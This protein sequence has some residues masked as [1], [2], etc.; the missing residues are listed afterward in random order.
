[1]PHF[2]DSMTRTQKAMVL[3]GLDGLAMAAAL[4]VAL[5]LRLGDP[6][7][8]QYFADGY[9]LWVL[10]P[11][12]G[13]LLSWI[14]G[15]PRIVLR[16]F[17]QRALFRLVQFAFIMSLI[18]A[19]LNTGLQFGLP[20]SIP[21][22]WAAVFLSFAI[23]SRLV[24]LG[25]IER[26]QQGGAGRKNVLVYGAGS[27]GQQLA[28]AL[29]SRGQVNPVGFLDDNPT[30][31]KVEVG[32]LRVHL[33]Q[34]LPSLIQRYGV[35]Q[36]ILAMPSVRPVDRR[37]KL[38]ALAAAGVEVLTLPSFDQ[39]LD[40]RVLTEQVRPV[41]T[42]ELLGRAAVDL[43]S[44]TVT[45]A[46]AGKVVMISGAGGS[47]GSELARQVVLAGPRRI[48]LFEQ[49]EYA[50]Y[51]IEREMQ[52]KGPEVVA[53]LGSVTDRARVDEV[54]RHQQV[55][56]ILHAA[57][58][59]HVPMIERNPLEGV[60]NNILGTASIADAA[61]AFGVERFILISTDKAVRPTNV[62]GATKRMA[63]LVVQDRQTRGGGTIFSMVR[64]G[65]VLGSSGSVIPLFREQIRNGGPVT[66][67]DP[68]VTRFFMTIPEAAQLVL[69]AGSYAEGGE[70]FV[71]D[72]GKPVK[73]MDL[74][75]S[76]IELSGFTVR[77]ENNRNGDIEIVTTGLR[78]GEKLY[79]ELLIDAATIATPHP[80]ILRA[81]EGHLSAED[82]ARALA[83]FAETVAQDRGADVAGL[84]Q[85]WLDGYTPTTRLEKRAS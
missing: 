10:V 23:F 6:W 52:D 34:A 55:D 85:K 60:R 22:I 20:R 78:P 59:K 31:R 26:L 41:S 39:L 70:V 32:G 9:G 35:D 28:A 18:T 64:F 65:N 38:E 15:V 17:E 67:T 54:L 82:T 83:Q 76:L 73:I 61:A 48:V 40:G 79:E 12:I 24:L 51:E 25:L 33:P 1:M 45:S 4:L 8:N 36:V 68:E 49:S 3:L 72:M 74:A 71:L 19:A 57:A 50:L 80:K 44:D 30:L 56:I 62:M 84:L 7:P 58:Y 46:Y 2:H 75:R 47:I 16:S 69:L 11:V 14:M 43:T 13:M 53:M 63:E 21:G 29:R 77:D 66:V 5:Q 37:E 27:T 81:A 42:D